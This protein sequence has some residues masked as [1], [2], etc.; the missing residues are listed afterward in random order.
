MLD[1]DVECTVDDIVLDFLLELINQHGFERSIHGIV[2]N[3]RRNA[4]LIFL[5]DSYVLNEDMSLRTGRSFFGVLLNGKIFDKKRLVRLKKLNVTL[6]NTIGELYILSQL[7]KEGVSKLTLQDLK[8]EAKA[9]SILSWYSMTK[10][11]VIQ[12]AEA[13]TKKAKAPGAPK[14]PKV[15]VPKTPKIDVLVEVK[16][17][18]KEEGIKVEESKSYVKIYGE[19]HKRHCAVVAGNNKLRLHLPFELDGFK[20]VKKDVHVGRFR[21][22]K[23]VE[24]GEVVTLVK[25]VIKEFDKMV[26]D[27]EKEVTKS[28][29]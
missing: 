8:K 12:M 15:Q 20:V 9:K 6:Y 13:K 26:K 10:D 21:Y 1:Y 2:A 19:G 5:P 16:K 24:A 27:K 29:K 23:Q 28:E 25:R 17:S 7:Q 18:L 11:E 3:R 4:Q 14:A 22:V